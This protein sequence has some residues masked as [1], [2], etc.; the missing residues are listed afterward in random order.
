ME[1]L[2]KFIKKL[3]TKT[4]LLSFCIAFMFVSLILLDL[5]RFGQPN[6]GDNI[7]QSIFMTV[8]IYVFITTFYS[9]NDKKDKKDTPTD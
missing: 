4:K 8:F 6:F 5:L 9:K 1:I 3:N 2:M 7:L